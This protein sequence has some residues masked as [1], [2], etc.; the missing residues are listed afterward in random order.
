MVMLR[1]IEFR[2]SRRGKT[3]RIS[4][5]LRGASTINLSNFNSDFTRSKASSLHPP[6]GIRT[7]VAQ[8]PLLLPALVISWVPAKHFTLRCAPSSETSTTTNRGYEYNGVE[9]M[10]FCC[11]SPVLRVSLIHNSVSMQSLLTEICDTTSIAEFE[12]E[13]SKFHYSWNLASSSQPMAPLISALI[14]ADT[15]VNPSELN[16]SASSSS[17]AI[18]KLLPVLGECQSLVDKVPKGECS[19]QSELPTIH[20]H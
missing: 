11:K 8:K 7:S 1:L 10:F 3:I 19:I 16:G 14:S 13:V 12:L 2:T 17:L 6:Y 9:S 18:S 5:S 4:G 15:S 20:M